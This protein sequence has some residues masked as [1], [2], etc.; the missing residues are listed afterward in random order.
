MTK[1]ADTH[2][3]HSQIHSQRAIIYQ[4]TLLN[5][6]HC[7]GI[8]VHSGTMVGMSIKEAPANTGYTF[9]RTDIPQHEK[10]ICN[11]VKAHWSTVVDTT[12]STK[13]SNGDGVTVGTI[14][15]VIAALAGLQIHNAI[16]EVDAPEIPIMDGS[17]AD[18]TTLLLTAGIKKQRSRLKTIRV[19]KPIQVSHSTSTAFLLPCNEPRITMAFNFNNRYE[20][21]HFSYY[22]DTDDFSKTLAPARTFGFYKDAER[23]RAL[24]LA[25]GASLDNTIVIGETGILNEDGL[26]YDDEF[27]RHKVLDAL[28]D[29]ALAGG[30]LLAHFDGTN[31]GHALNNKILRALFSDP[32]AWIEEETNENSYPLYDYP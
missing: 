11:K 2:Q 7:K 12:L 17:S 25:Q 1:L 21:S 23:L 26:R 16:I 5:P 27:V 4:Q 18:F 20:T 10:G 30:R 15:H 29:L 9:I 3:V 19:L 13:I 24:G 28:G 31:S 22:P 32:A 6:I 8:G 14:E